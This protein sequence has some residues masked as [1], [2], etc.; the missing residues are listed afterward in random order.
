MSLNFASQ[1][2][3]LYI[4]EAGMPAPQDNFQHQV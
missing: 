4:E 3:S 2:P 1:A